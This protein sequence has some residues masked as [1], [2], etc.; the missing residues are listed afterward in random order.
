[1]I[2]NFYK[3]SIESLAC[4]L[5]VLVA[6]GGCGPG[7]V[8][9]STGD[10]AREALETALST[11]RDG[12]KPGSIKATAPSVQVFDT[13]WTQGDVLKDYEIV[14]NE[15]GNAEHEFSVK[16][17][18]AK[19]AKVEEVTYHVL[20][21]DPLMIFRHEDYLRNINMENGPSLAAPNKQGRRKLR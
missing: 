8:D 2:K 18:L 3:I 10:A 21:Q 13:P 5:L 17:T 12:G 14:G 16:L 1:M 9:L 15:S 19:P 6:G 11:W 7:A 4:S 20:G